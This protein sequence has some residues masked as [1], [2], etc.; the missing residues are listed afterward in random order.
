MANHKDDFL[1]H[2]Q[3]HPF[4]PLFLKHL[5][6]QRPI[7]PGFDPDAD[8]TEKWKFLTAQQKGF[9]LCL[10]IFNINPE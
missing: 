2:V 7:V 8:N 10:S 6:S 5:K 4:F 9:D 1:I 3:T